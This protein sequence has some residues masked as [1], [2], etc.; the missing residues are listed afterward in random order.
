MP[1]LKEELQESKDTDLIKGSKLLGE[2]DYAAVNSVRSNFAKIIDLSNND[3]KKILITEHKK[4]AAAVVPV[5]EFR[6]LMLLEKVG[7]TENLKKLTYEDISPDEALK[8]LI[9]LSN[10]AQLASQGATE[11]ESED[12]DQGRRD[13][14]PGPQAA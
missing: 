3:G 1:A 10:A 2:A 6:I 8:K 13:H 5:S 14:P 4:P 11:G 7:M 12:H 9:K